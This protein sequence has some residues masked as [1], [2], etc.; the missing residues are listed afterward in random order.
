MIEKSSAGE[1]GEGEGKKLNKVVGQAMYKHAFLMMMHQR[2]KMS[3]SNQ[4]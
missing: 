2:F 1:F 3:L 4:W